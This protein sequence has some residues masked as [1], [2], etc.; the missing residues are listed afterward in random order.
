MVTYLSKFIPNLSEISAPLRELLKQDIV[1]EWSDSQIASFNKLKTLITSAPVLRYYDVSAP[2][3]LSVDSSKDGQGACILQDGHP[4]AYASRALTLTQRDGYSQLEKE[5]LAIVFGCQKFHQYVYGKQVLVESDHRPLSQIFRKN[6]CQLTPRVQRM[7][8]H[9]QRYDLDVTYK[10]GKELLLA[11]TLSRAYLQ[12]SNDSLYDELLDVNMVN[13][14]LMTAEKLQAFQRATRDSA[15]LTELR[16]IVANGWP[17]TRDKC[18]ELVRPYWDYRDEIACM[19]NLLFKSDRVIVPESLRPE[20]LK[21]I[22]ESH[23]GI[24]R[25]KQ[26]ARRSV[27]AWYDQPDSRHC[28]TL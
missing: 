11:D 21:R 2:I 26:S 10:P 25:C 5:L 22:H 16:N 18:P 7:V 27:L 17:S 4:V 28:G 14:L 19:D 3:I 15:S 12:E 23:Q 20:T 6:L 1:F 13:T 9:L 24:D 8:L